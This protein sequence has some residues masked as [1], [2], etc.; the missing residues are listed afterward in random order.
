MKNLFFI[1]KI[2]LL[3]YKFKTIQ[4]ITEETIKHHWLRSF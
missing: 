4:P 2:L 3:K 1:L